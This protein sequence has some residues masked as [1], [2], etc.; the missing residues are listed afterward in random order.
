MVFER[1]RTSMRR[2]KCSPVTLFLSAV[3]GALYSTL[4]I[5]LF[6]FTSL[7]SNAQ[8][9]YEGPYRLPSN[10]SGTSVFEYNTVG[11]DTVF[12]G[13]FSFL[14]SERSGENDEILTGRN[15]F[16]IY[17]QGKKHGQ[18]SYEFKHFETE[19]TPILR[20]FDI[21]KPG[22]G[23]DQLISGAFQDGVAHGPWKVLH[24]QILRGESSDSLL[25]ARAQMLNGQ[26]TGQIDGRFPEVTIKGSFD[27]EGML[28]DT[29]KIEHVLADGVKL[30]E[31]REYENGRFINHYFELLG[32]RFDV[33]HAGFDTR[34]DEGEVWQ[35]I[36]LSPTYFNVFY[37]STT[38][39]KSSAGI[40][41]PAEIEGEKAKDFIDQT[42]EYLKSLLFSFSLNK[43]AKV[44]DELPGSEPLATGMLRLRVHDYPEESLT[45]LRKAANLFRDCQK[46]IQAFFKDPQIDISRYSY[47]D[48]NYFEKVMAQY[49]ASSRQLGKVVLLLTEDAFKYVDREVVY[50]KIAPVIEYPDSV[51]YEFKDEIYTRHFDF[52]EITRINGHA[53]YLQEHLSVIHMDLI[54]IEEQ[55]SQTLEQYK[56][57]SEL[58]GKEEQLVQKRDSIAALFRGELKPGAFNSFHDRFAGEVTSAATSAFKFYGGLSLEK[59]LDTLD[60]I[61]TCFDELIAFHT[62]IERLPVRVERL[63]EVYS[64]TVWNPFTFTDMDERV[65]ERVYRAYETI[66]LPAVLD[67]LEQNLNCG[68]VASKADNLR[69]IYQRLIDIR[70]QDTRELER[71]LRKTTDIHVIIELLH[72]NLDMQ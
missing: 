63:D 20:G 51:Q 58:A 70:E 48:I 69:K 31:F 6:S 41:V 52:P 39:V 9:I 16:G 61:L 66:L 33:L 50:E 55:I 23:E 42:N 5:G 54:Q 45:K 68:N 28:H 2:K 14:S 17:K 29:W 12:N 18:W 57:Q 72:L 44:W 19:A 26:F 30:E 38:D 7:T 71:E 37:H 43:G 1:N 35:D 64:R 34:E 60:Q 25:S 36:A 53:A 13:K 24:Q 67:D 3:S 56:K 8:R 46:I 59:K 47:E 15:Y 11:S 40:A 49:D 10:I 22:S 27:S 65:K 4:F 32:Q 21:V 62:A